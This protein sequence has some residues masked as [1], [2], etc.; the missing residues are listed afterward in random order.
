MADKDKIGG[1]LEVGVDDKGQ[2]VINHADLT[3]DANGVGHIIFSP[4][5]ARTLGLLLLRKASDADGFPGTGE[6]GEYFIEVN[7]NVR[8]TTASAVRVRID[9]PAFD[10][11]LRLGDDLLDKALYEDP[12]Y[13]K[14]KQFVEFNP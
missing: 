10:S 13:F 8:K 2:V 11:A 1:Y 6:E 14:L 4:A 3:P 9:N 7:R 12:L 5:Q